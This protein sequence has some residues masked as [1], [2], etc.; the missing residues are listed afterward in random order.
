MK[1]NQRYVIS[2]GGSLIVP[3][4]IAVR[5]LKKFRELVVHEVRRGTKFLILTGGGRTC[6]IYQAAARAFGIQQTDEIDWVG[7]ESCN[8]NARLVRGLFQ[9]YAFKNY[10]THPKQAANR[11]EDILIASGGLAP[12]GSSDSTT[13][14]YARAVKSKIMVNL[15]DVDGIYDKNPRKFK[16]GRV[17]AHLTWDDFEKQ[18]GTSRAPGQHV[19]FDPSAAKISQKIGLK[20]VI[21]NGQNLKN[22]RNFFRGQAFRGT[23]V[24]SN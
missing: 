17:I 12:G 2:L 13:V 21:L 6:R 20:L 16:N 18:F 7:M 8:L 19:P 15:T 1:D 22:L 11:Q 10:L 3:D 14:A 24:K 4:K 23:V 5:Y 9:D